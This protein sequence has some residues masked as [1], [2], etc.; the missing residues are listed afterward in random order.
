RGREL[1]L[2]KLARDPQ[3]PAPRRDGPVDPP[4][5]PEL[6]MLLRRRALRGKQRQKG[7]RRKDRASHSSLHGRGLYTDCLT[8]CLDESAEERIM[9]PDVRDNI[10][11]GRGEGKAK[12]AAW[13]GASAHERSEQPSLEHFR[14]LLQ[15]YM[16][17]KGLRSTDQRRLIVERFFTAPN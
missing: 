3:R 8:Y 13:G 6:R 14:S 9:D 11:R 5:I 17:K 2:Q 12:R 10:P 16:V 15:Q 4:V 1:L 7:H